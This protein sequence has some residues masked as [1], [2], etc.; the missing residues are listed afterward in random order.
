MVPYTYLIGWSEWNKFYYGVRYA[1]GCHPSDLW[2]TYFTSSSRVKQ[3]AELYG[4][5]DIVKIRKTFKDVETATQ[6]EQKV[7]RRLKVNKDDRW[8]NVTY[9]GC[10]TFR[11]PKNT[12]P[13]CKAAA[14][15][16]KGVPKTQEHNDKNS[17]GQ[18]KITWTLT[19]P[20]GN[21]F[22]IKNL[23]KFCKENNL[24]TGA[25]CWIA[26]GKYKSDNYKGWKCTQ[27]YS[28]KEINQME[29]V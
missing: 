15:V 1:R 12:M 10:F 4:T 13:G 26:K 6:W 11:G 7:L 14:L 19:D 29:Q 9:N 17:K 5:P 22:H 27:D 3:Y 28:R 16:T 20:D 25:L 24:A 8:L 2:V 23:N 21:I 18:S